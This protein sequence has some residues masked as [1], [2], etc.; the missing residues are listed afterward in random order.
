V[1]S[2][3]TTA[4]DDLGRVS[5]VMDGRRVLLSFVPEDAEQIVELLRRREAEMGNVDAG[6]PGSP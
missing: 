1:I 3:A 6:G 4:G 2:A 5:L